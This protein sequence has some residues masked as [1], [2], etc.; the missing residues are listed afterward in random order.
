MPSSRKPNELV[1]F[2]EGHKHTIF[3]TFDAHTALSR[4]QNLLEDVQYL[5]EL[6][7]AA[8]GVGDRGRFSGLEITDYYAAGY[9]TCLEWHARS[10]R[11]DLLNFMPDLILP[12][13]IRDL[14]AISQM[15][16]AKVTLADLIGASTK[17]NTLGNYTDVF[18]TIWSALGIGTPLAGILQDSQRVVGRNGCLYEL[19]GR[20]H[21]LVHEIGVA[22]VSS[23]LLRD[24]WTF[25]DASAH[26]RMIVDLIQNIEKEISKVAPDDFPNKLDQDGYPQD[27]QDVLQ[28]QLAEIEQRVAS[29]MEVNGIGDFTNAKKSFADYLEVQ[30]NLVEHALIQ[31]PK[32]HYDPTPRIIE[33]LYK[34]RVEF[35]SA[36]AEELGI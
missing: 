30:V 14:D 6:H 12:G 13:M 28:R 24:N 3:P 34:Q 2:A 18:E 21:A 4:A 22:Q 5:S 32:R 29:A 9:V 16:S 25:E 8:G 7:G 27:R 31:I 19:F 10:R 17:I 11:A 36:I 1:A 20:R 26:G 15:P 35:L 23:Y 33:M